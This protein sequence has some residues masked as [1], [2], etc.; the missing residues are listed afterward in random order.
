M[1]NYIKVEPEDDL[2]TSYLNP[3]YLTDLPLSPPDSSFTGSPEKQVSNDFLLDMNNDLL[4]DWMNPYAL[5]QPD[6][7]GTLFSESTIPEEPVKKKRGRKKREVQ[8]VTQ[9]SLLAPKPIVALSPPAE[10]KPEDERDLQQ[11]KR[12]ERLIKNRA[13][14]LLSRKRKREHLDSLEDENKRLSGQVDELEKR[15]QALEKENFELKQ[16]LGGN[17]NTRATSLVFMI[18]FF[19]FALFTL[20][21]RTLNN[22]LTVGGSSSSAIQRY[23]S[24]DSA[25]YAVT[26]FCKHGDCNKQ[27]KD[28]VLIDS[29]RPRD[30]QTWISRKLEKTEENKQSHLYLYSKEFSQMASVAK[31]STHKGKPMLSLI[32]PFNQTSDICDRY[33]QIDVQILG[34][35]VIDGHLMSLQQ[36][37]YP[38]AL[39]DGMKKDLITYPR[40][41]KKQENKSISAPQK[42][43]TKSRVLL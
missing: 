25:S 30:L 43:N 2:I 13:A 39:L 34:S 37:D 3:E 29:V 22:Q 21:S 32:S 31:S 1:T 24:L 41:K 33:L 36:Y 12:Q 11:A 23:P 20:P 28:L 6:F 15:V 26:P 40:I 16:K 9:P 38:S 42:N 18:F 35:K 10:N 5:E 4:T 17:T 27:T 14:A 8:P 7:L 19:S